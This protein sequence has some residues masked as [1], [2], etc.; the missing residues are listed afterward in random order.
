[1]GKVN[2]LRPYGEEH[3]VV[4]LYPEQGA[5]VVATA[6]RN[7][8]ELGGAGY[9]R[10][11]RF[12]EGFRVSQT[13]RSPAT[14][15]SG[16]WVIL[17]G[18]ENEVPS[19]RWRCRE[20]EPGPRSRVPLPGR[21]GFG[22]TETGVAPG[23]MLGEISMA[24]PLAKTLVVDD[25]PG[26]RQLVGL[27]L[28]RDGHTVMP[29]AEGGE[30]L[31]LFRQTRPDLVVLDLMLPGPSGLE[32]CRRIRSERSVPLIL[33]TSRDKEE[34]GIAGLELGVGDYVMK[35]FSPRELAAACVQ[36][37]RRANAFSAGPR[38]GGCSTSATCAWSPILT[39]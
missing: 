39:E 8:L 9:P 33:L 18:R 26:V 12:V 6:W 21:G 38:P 3:V 37:G 36:A 19:G 14:A 11:R 23:A 1:M 30:A 13:A 31:R 15:A 24:G 34:D 35:P 32:V 22:D 2:A 20:G 28:R 29:A 5:P 10:P 25:E 7:Q 27:H 17:G 16:V 4:S